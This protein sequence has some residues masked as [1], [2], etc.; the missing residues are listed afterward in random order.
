MLKRFAALSERM[1]FRLLVF[2]AVVL[3]AGLMI[4]ISEMANRGAGDR[5]NQLVVL[6]RA[7]VQALHLMRRISDAESGKRGYLLVGGE[8]YL[9]PYRLANQDVQKMLH[10][11]EVLFA[12]ADDPQAEARRRDIERLV[13]D[14]FK[15]MDDVLALFDA[16][17]KEEA[18]AMVRSGVGEKLMNEL[19]QQVDGLITHQNAEIEVG[20]RRVHDT[21]LLSRIGVAAMTAL[22]LL[23][24][25]LFARQGR[26]LT[27]QREERQAE[28][29]AERD[30]LEQEVAR[31][32]SDLTELA[33]HLQT[34]LEDERGR[35]ARELHDELGALLTAAKLDVARIKP[36]IQHTLP[37]L[38]PRLT[39]LTESLNSGIA[40]KRRIIEDL[41]PSTLS[42]LGLVPAL[43]I[44]CSE[45]RERSG[46]AVDVLIE[47]VDLCPNADL[48]VYR[49]VQEALTN[50]AKYAKAGHV[51]I[52]LRE[53]SGT[54][55]LS[56]TDD[57]VGFD[58]AQAAGATHGLR[59]MRFRVEAERGTLDVV[60][61]PGQG[62]ALHARLPLGLGR[63]APTA[64]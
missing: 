5:L 40:L 39:H 32:T 13:H 57:G 49:V 24:L 10:E 61:H 37:E 27:R 26:T 47:P 22:S 54:A 42:S 44:L 4:G 51:S 59:G 53:E 15:E 12:K 52:S 23:M 55:A 19:R 41:R 34:A 2:P 56:I 6:G 18:L 38:M 1:R 17:R 7:R 50:I 63:P 28:I 35:L 30:R 21:L 36:S 3:A 45:F 60:T 16:G 8:A 46:M 9:Q 43:E 11:L 62:T 58:A 20:L 25:L 48:T 64:H 31:R 29:R 33:R 14:K